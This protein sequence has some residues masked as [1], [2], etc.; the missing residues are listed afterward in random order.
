MHASTGTVRRL[1]I[2]KRGEERWTIAN[3]VCGPQCSRADAHD[4]LLS[5]PRSGLELVLLPAASSMT[6][7]RPA[8]ATLVQTPVSEPASSSQSSKATFQARSNIGSFPVRRLAGAPWCSTTGPDPTS[9]WSCFRPTHPPCSKLSDRMRPCSYASSIQESCDSARGTQVSNPV[10]FARLISLNRSPGC[11][12]FYDARTQS[13][14]L[15]GIGGRH[16][17]GYGGSDGR[18]PLTR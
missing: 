7:M 4:E 9:S 8:E 16:F 14:A 13:T 11:V 2:R 17:A 5:N 1:L 3:S 18:F 12:R 15:S 10:S 6:R